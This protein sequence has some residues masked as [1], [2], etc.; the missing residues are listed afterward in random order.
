MTAFVFSIMPIAKL[1]F[2]TGMGIIS[3]DKARTRKIVPAPGAIGRGIAS[4][5]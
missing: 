3:L 1:R 4:S 5:E 2:A